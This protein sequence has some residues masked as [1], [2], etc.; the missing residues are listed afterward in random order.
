M[1]KYAHL[2]H[3][4]PDGQVHLLYAVYVMAACLLSLFFKESVI[5]LC[6]IIT[7]DGVNIDASFSFLIVLLLSFL[8]KRKVNIFGST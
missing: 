3:F 6:F 1:R 2:G 4:H 7:V 5:C 8:L